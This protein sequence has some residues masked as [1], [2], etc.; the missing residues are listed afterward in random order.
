M[1]HSRISEL[2]KNFGGTP[3]QGSHKNQHFIAGLGYM[4]VGGPYSFIVNE[5]VTLY[6]TSRY[7]YYQDH[8][9]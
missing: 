3:K 8:V 5:S 2:Q 6:Y 7:D 1:H 4:P 9:A